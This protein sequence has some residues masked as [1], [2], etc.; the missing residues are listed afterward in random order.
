MKSFSEYIKDR[1]QIEMPTEN[2][3]GNWFSKHS[4]PMVV[5]CACCDMSMASPSAWIDEDGYVY[6]G[7]CAEA[8][9]NREEE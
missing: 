1:W 3:P 8:H 2:I 7:T 5:R 9:M 4:L 6:C